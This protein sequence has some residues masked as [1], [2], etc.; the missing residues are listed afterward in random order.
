MLALPGSAYLYQGEELGLP[1]ATTL[2]MAVRQDPTI[3]RGGGLGRDGCRVPLPWESAAPAYG[4]S[5]TGESWLPQPAV[6]GR[7]ALDAQKGD[8]AST[9]EFYRHAL[10]TRRDYALG[11]GGLAWIDLD[12]ADVLG[13]SNGEL[14][15]IANTGERQVRLPEGLEPIIAS[16]DLDTHADGALYLPGDTTLWAR[17]THPEPLRKPFGPD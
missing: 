11:S 9:Y 16:A 10:R 17:R 4:F 15:V 12:L 3:A 5:P 7:L 14:V 13:L 2:E 8:P 1:E 6:Y